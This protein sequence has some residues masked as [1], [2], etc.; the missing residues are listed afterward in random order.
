MTL[1]AWFY[2]CPPEL[3]LNLADKSLVF[4]IYAYSEYQQYK[5]IWWHFGASGDPHGVD[6]Q[7]LYENTTLLAWSGG[8]PIFNVE[9]STAQA[10]DTD[11][12]STLIQLRDK[13]PWERVQSTENTYGLPS[14][15]IK[16]LTGK[17]HYH[18]LTPE[19]L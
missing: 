13:S 8:S 18:R 16:A 10:G 15:V 9:A 4:T 2:R 6:G 3:G 5:L 14:S 19:Y 1:S 17:D 7:L 12:L 11:T